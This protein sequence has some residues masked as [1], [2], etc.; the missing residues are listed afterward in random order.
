MRNILLV[1]AI[2]ISFC[3]Q[4]SWLVTGTDGSIYLSP[5]THLLHSQHFTPLQDSIAFKMVSIH[6]GALACS[7]SQQ[8]QSQPLLYR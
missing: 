7:L 5:V 4:K 8:D 1:L 6:F 3:L 2:N